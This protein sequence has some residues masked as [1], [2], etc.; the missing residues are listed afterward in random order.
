MSSRRFFATQGPYGIE[1]HLPLFFTLKKARYQIKMPLFWVFLTLFW[2]PALG[3]PKRALFD[4]FWAFSTPFGVPRPL[5]ARPG[6]ARPGPAPPGPARP[7]ARPAARPGPARPDP[8]RPRPDPDP[9]PGSVSDSTS[10]STHFLQIPNL[11]KRGLA[12]RANR[13]CRASGPVLDRVAVG[14]CEYLRGVLPGRI[15]GSGGPPLMHV[16]CTPP[17]STT[18]HYW[19]YQLR[20][21]CSS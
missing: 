2:G 7:A 12:L 8:A 17:C 4:P 5:Q 15:F 3:T 10:G 14:S 9:D 21:T 1:T 20:G 19:W 11:T 18:Y 6:P 16:A 13:R